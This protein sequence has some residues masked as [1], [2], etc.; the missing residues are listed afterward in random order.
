MRGPDGNLRDCYPIVMSFMVDYP[1]AS[2]ICL[3][4]TN[5]SC[6]RCMISPGHF[7][8]LD[9]ISRPRTVHEMQRI[10]ARA[11]DLE[12]KGKHKVAEDVLQEHGL[13]GLTVCLAFNIVHK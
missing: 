13:W 4:R 5:Q 8:R 3:T 12:S 1:E 9:E 7:G 10:V 11:Q 2:L 6:P